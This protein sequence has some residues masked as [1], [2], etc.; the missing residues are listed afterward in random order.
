M[1]NVT[2]FRERIRLESPKYIGDVYGGSE[3]TWEC[4][5]ELFA[6]DIACTTLSDE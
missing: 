5:E 3:V 4:V 6:C 2:C 1:S